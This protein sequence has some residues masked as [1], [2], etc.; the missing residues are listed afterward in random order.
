LEGDGTFRGARRVLRLALAQG[1]YDVVHVHAAPS[2]V[3][4]MMVRNHGRHPNRV[5]TM[6][7]EYKNFRARNRM[8]LHVV[9]ARYP[10]VVLCSESVRQSL[11]RLLRRLGGKRIYVVP[12]GV[13]MER[14]D[15][16]LSAV[17]PVSDPR[18]F[19]AVSVGRLIPIKDPA[20]LLRAFAQAS[21][22]GE[23]LVYVGAGDL[24]EDVAAEAGRLG[25]ADRVRMTGLVARDDV[26]REVSAA[27]V[28]V[29]VSHGEGLPVA[30]LEAMACG[31][32]VILSDIPPHREIAAGVDFV[33]LVPPGDV[34]GFAAE[35]ARI[36]SMSDEERRRLG[37]RCRVLVEERFS[38]REMHRSYERVYDGSGQTPASIGGHP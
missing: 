1:P 9:F 29:S 34:D 16:V 8:L 2:A 22:D 24:Q 3:L 12:N 31:R 18:G 4:L 5:F 32:P 35:L 26:Y 23:R 13:D 36:R 17:P 11:P 14:I 33:P 27:D 20:L 10:T 25:V 28:F 37:E 21:H 15:R 6:H 30:V 19:T 7:N 38:L